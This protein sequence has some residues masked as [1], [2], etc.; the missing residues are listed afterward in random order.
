MKLNLQFLYVALYLNYSNDAPKLN[1]HKYTNYNTIEIHINRLSTTMQIFIAMDYSIDDRE[2]L[3]LWKKSKA[4]G[5]DT[6][7][8]L[9]R[10][11]WIHELWKYYSNG[12]SV[13]FFKD[14]Y[15]S[16]KEIGIIKAV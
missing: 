15:K 3:S 1:M 2:V 12:A 10:S 7:F 9:H 11:N 4:F 16:L 5:K 13:Q 14:R 8:P 6:L